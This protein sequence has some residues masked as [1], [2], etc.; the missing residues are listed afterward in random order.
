MRVVPEINPLAKTAP[1][2][3]STEYESAGGP[4]AGIRVLDWTHV[5]AGPQA[6]FQLAALGADVIRLENPRS[7]DIVR[8]KAADPALA[9][10]GLGEGYCMLGAGRCTVAL[11]AASMLGRDAV[12]ALI[13]SC[14]VVLENFRPGKLDALG[15]APQRLIAEHSKLIVCS[16]TGFPRDSDQ[17]DRPAYDH[18]IQAASGL[19]MANTDAQGMPRR[20]GFPVVDYVVGMHAASAVVAALYR[21][22]A[23]QARG[24]KRSQGE[25]LQLSMLETASMLL[26]PSYAAQAISG[27][28]V[29]RSASTAYSGS[30]LSG[31]FETRQGYIAL[32]CNNLAQSHRLMQALRAAQVAE[33]AV[34]ALQASAMA[35]DVTLAQSQLQTMVRQHDA[36][37][38]EDHLAAHDVPCAQLRQPYEAFMQTRRPL[39]V[40]AGVHAQAR[41][42]QLASAGYSSSEALHG[43]LR[44]PKPRGWDTMAVLRELGWSEQQIQD[45]LGNQAAVQHP[46][47][48]T[49][50]RSDETA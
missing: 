30:A 6:A 20:V 18:V 4:L 27:K 24:E 21:R 22:L 31:T 28:E 23:Q 12:A 34:R 43:K 49:G 3:S 8:S 37:F 42:V 41:V 19:M 29:P 26:S 46:L 39:Q 25:W 16:I 1:P 5:L 32:V 17:A 38:W 45:A 13:A 33:D 47:N 15:F 40:R 2:S 35:S 14:D 9:E 48:A 7:N 36:Q 44:D 10:Q 50:E 11:D